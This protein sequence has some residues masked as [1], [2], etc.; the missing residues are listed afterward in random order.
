MIVCEI[1]RVQ[2]FMKDLAND[3]KIQVQIMQLEKNKL[4][5]D[6]HAGC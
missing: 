4:D 5:Y 1:M 2:A 3:V 6:P